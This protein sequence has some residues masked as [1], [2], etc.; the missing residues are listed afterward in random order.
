MK[1]TFFLLGIPAY[2]RMLEVGKVCP[3]VAPKNGDDCSDIYENKSI[4]SICSWG[5]DPRYECRAHGQCMKDK[6]KESKAFWKVD[7]G[8][9]GV[10]SKNSTSTKS[11]IFSDVSNS[12]CNNLTKGDICMEYGSLCSYEDGSYCVCTRSDP[13]PCFTSCNIG[14]EAK[15]QCVPRMNTENAN[16][17]NFAPNSGTPC[18]VSGTKCTYTCEHILGCIDGVWKY[19]A[20]KCPIC[21]APNTLITTSL[22]SGYKVPISDLKAGDVVVSVD[23]KGEKIIV[24]I[25]EVSKTPVQNHHVVKV[26]LENN[27]TLLISPGHPISDGRTFN[28]LKSG[29]YLHENKILSVEI[30]PY[31]Y[32]YTYDILPQSNT[33]SYFAEGVL[34]GSTLV[35]SSSMSSTV[36][37]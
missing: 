22:S 31:P 27:S 13:Y 36:L 11:N 12:T 26:I 15:W 7:V 8:A 1:L 3:D 20:G 29:D 33:G 4:V 25:V 14:L 16:C 24:P 28:D 19:K 21:A 34:I 10:D 23:E 6:I 32:D 18:S 37:S 2:S 5:E 17:P 30:M 9:C 35:S